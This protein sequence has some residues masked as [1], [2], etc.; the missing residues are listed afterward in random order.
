MPRTVAVL[1][2]GK[3]SAKVAVVDLATMTEGDVLTTPND[4]VDAPPYPHF[5]T[6][7]LWS[8]FLTSLAALN[9]Q[10]PLE[11]I[12]VTAH[13]ASGA[14]LDREGGLAA[15]VLDY[16]HP[17]PEAVGAAYDALRPPFALTGAP[18]LSGG[19]NL[20]AQIHWQK[21]VLPGLDARLA[22]LV[23]WPQYWAMRLSGVA[24][25]EVTSLGAH[26]DLWVPAARRFS[27]LVAALGLDGRIA[28]LRRASDVLGPVLPTVAA[29]AGLGEEVRVHCGIHDSN[30]SLYPHLLSRKAPF[31]VVST[32][33]WVI[34]FAVGSGAKLD[35]AR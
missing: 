23:T 11:A 4:I 3:T 13:G 14:L 21:S 34:V 31:S 15:P 25:T 20:G 7:A 6:E 32:G 35:P 5:D 22:T 12:V 24:T 10:S 27:P 16:D 1:D 17:G 33:T 28:P 29:A 8:F 2:I 18:R 26:T 9:R 19:L 30:A